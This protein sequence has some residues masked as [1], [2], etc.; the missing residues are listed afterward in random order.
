M[1]WT[2]RARLAAFLILGGATP[3]LAQDAPPPVEG[4][5]PPDEAP[6]GE[7]SP[8]EAE[9]TR[10]REEA[11]MAAALQQ[12]EGPAAGVETA[13]APASE[14]TGAT[15]SSRGL[16]NLLNPAI[17]GN[18]LLLAGYSSRDEEDA[19]EE[20]ADLETGLSIQELEVALSAII[21]PFLRADMVLTASAEEI[22]FEEAYVTTLEIPHLAVRGGLIKAAVG[23][24]NILHSHAFP[25]L[26][27][28]LP[29]RA[30][31]GPEGLAAPGVSVDLLIPLPWYTELNLQVLDD[32]FG[33]PWAIL[34]NQT[35]DDPDTEIDESLDRRALEDL[36]YVAHLKTLFD[37]SASTTLEVGA[38]VV[39]GR[40][41]FDG[42]TSLVAGDMTVKWRPVAAARYTSFDWQTEVLWLDR[43]HAPGEDPI[44]GAHTHLRYQFAQQWW[45][46]GRGAVLGIPGSKDER[47]WRGEALAAFVPDEFSALRL[48]YGLE[49]AQAEGA[50]FVHDVF[51]QV[52]FSMG[53]HPAHAY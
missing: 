30:L 24:H 9:A 21:D 31:L 46:Q 32:H 12:A 20:R 45:V 10:A 16:S 25:F 29:W 13:R 22:G 19:V 35:P 6:P 51:L 28:P 26:T 40:N 50:S 23:R 7:P 17:S 3:A 49:R 38:T 15:A 37:L 41:A 33:E 2:G 8:S 5:A 53:P 42:W 4:G 11:D 39:G 34:A 47:V 48:Q 36:A 27:G 14:G 18:G 43:G 44:G 1:D 52:I